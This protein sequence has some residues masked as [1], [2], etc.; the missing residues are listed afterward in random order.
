[1][2]PGQT[3]VLVA[4]R[5]F[6]ERARERSFAISTAISVAILVA[7]ILLPRAFDGGAGPSRVGVAGASPEAVAP[8]LEGRP[9]DGKA[10]EVERFAT[11]AAAERAL[12]AGD[13]DA[14]VVDGRIL[15]EDELPE[16]LGTVVQAASAE[17]RARAALAEQ[18]ITGPAADRILAPPPL[19]VDAVAPNGGGDGGLAFVAVIVLYGQVF[20]YGFWVASG[21]VEEKASRI[22]E[23]LL[24]AIR[25]RQLLAGKIV[26]I[27]LLGLLQL[28]AIAAA[29]LAIAIAA[30]VV[31]AP[32]RALTT[33]GIA[34]AWFVLGYAFYAC[35]FAVSGAVIS[36]VEDLQNATTPLSL[37]LVG[38]LVV[39]FVA[40]NDP[41]GALAEVASIVPP[42]SAM[43]MPPRIAAGEVA[44]WEVALAAGLLLAATVALVPIAARVY[45]NAVLRT[46]RRVRLREV[47]RGGA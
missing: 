2:S 26:G 5:E 27:G 18:G 20:A 4:R 19:A 17:A 6:T 45:K 22:V 25:P 39:A 38:S 13:V 8:L 15:V 11:S 12:R 9:V 14:V 30:D 43:V 7:V 34:V 35:L 41:E 31:E 37:A 21:V 28:V 40:I 29:G 16:E 47:W 44:A 3:V 10:V 1:M 32:G 46:G 23:I 33:A 42:V 36:R 24:A